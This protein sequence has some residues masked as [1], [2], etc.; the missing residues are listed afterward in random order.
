MP[1]MDGYE[2]VQKLRQLPAAHG[3]RTPAVA[4]TAFART[5]D[6]SRAFLSGFDMFL[7]KPVDPAELMALVVNLA[8]RIRGQDGERITPSAPVRSSSLK[9]AGATL[10]LTDL[11]VLVVD[12]ETDARAQL[13]RTLA[14][15]GAL[16]SVAKSADDALRQCAALDPD[17]L[18]CSLAL[19]DRDGASLL[20]ELRLQNGHR[21]MPA[22]ALIRADQPGDAKRAILAG[23]QAHL[24]HRD[25]P[26]GL[27]ARVAKLAA[28]SYRKTPP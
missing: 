4:L 11:E 2:L 5:E 26:D 21:T 23:F 12:T 28:W 1:Q 25:G 9:V 16:V 14:N 17:V 27:V 7:P 6:R 24:P 15:A 13:V 3:G 20:R 10:P 19:P 8:Q 22:I 18:I